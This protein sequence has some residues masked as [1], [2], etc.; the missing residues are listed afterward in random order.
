MLRV[1]PSQVV[2]VVDRLFPWAETQQEGESRHL[3][4]GSEMQ[5]M[6]MVRMVDKIPEELLQMAPEDYAVLTV[7]VEAIRTQIETWRAQGDI[8]TLDCIG[9]LPNLSPVTL[10]RHCLRKCP[11]EVPSP[12]TAVLLFIGDPALRNS[13]RLDISAANQDLVGG[14]W[15]GATVLAGAAAEALLLYGLQQHD[16]A[17][18]G[19]IS[20]AIATLSASGKIKPSKPDPELWGLHEYIEVAAELGII[21]PETAIE[22]RQTKNYRNLIHPGRSQRLKQACD[23]G[24]ALSALAAVE[25]VI[26]DLTP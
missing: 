2:G 24:T 7:A 4:I 25:F 9:G 10:I 11:D 22:L 20:T 16:V 17:H 13:I 15:K 8:G 5:L 21:K 12:I 26:R 1:F 14:N 18:S 3:Y 23:R 6:G 19:A